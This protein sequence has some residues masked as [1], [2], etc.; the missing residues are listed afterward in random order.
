MA[1]I[2]IESNNID[3]NE[4][5]FFAR[6]LEY[7]KT[8]TYDIKYPEYQATTLMPVDSSAGPGAETITY[9]QYD[10]VGTMKIMASYADDAPRADVKGQEFFTPVKS[11]RGAYGYNI[12]EIRNAIFAKRPLKAMKATSAREAYEQTVNDIAWFADGSASYG[13][14]RGLIY[15]LNTT[16]NAAPTGNWSTASANDIIADV[17]FA[18]QTPRT[19]TLKTEIVNTVL[20]PV[21]Q[22][23][24]ISTKPRSD[25]SDTTILEFLQRVNKNVTFVDVNELDA[26]DPK[27]SGGAGPVDILIAYRRDPNRFQLQ[28]PQ[29]FEQF[30]P[31]ER[32]L[33]FVVNTHARI[34]GVT[35][36]YPLSIHI[37]EGI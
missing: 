17:N 32:N 29:P 36:Y 1:P 4:A 30:N 37:V 15:S 9:R 20:I 10:R 5:I 12:Q 22:Y 11:L 31:Q 18:I 33:E 3:A 35:I 34:G 2:V 21:G 24:D 23:G 7:V 27:P 13:G 26:L 6:E 19:I 28:I 8:Q 14:L 25:Y 16:K